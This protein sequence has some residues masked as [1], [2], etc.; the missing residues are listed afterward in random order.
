[1]IDGF[2]KN[3][4]K[5]RR[6]LSGVTQKIDIWRFSRTVGHPGVALVVKRR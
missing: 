4:E 2:R 1:M 5:N 3:Q 6:T